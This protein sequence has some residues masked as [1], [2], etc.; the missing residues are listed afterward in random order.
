[1]GICMSWSILCRYGKFNCLWSKQLYV[2]NQGRKNRVWCH[3]PR[4]ILLRSTIKLVNLMYFKK[5]KEN[6]VL[7]VMWVKRSIT[8]QVLLQCDFYIKFHERLEFR[9]I[10]WFSII[11]WILKQMHFDVLSTHELVCSRDVRNLP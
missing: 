9:S 10:S 5:E 7:L 6:E 1:M 8:M 3:I 11:T 4:K 2:S